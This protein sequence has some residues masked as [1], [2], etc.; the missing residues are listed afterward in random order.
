MT[1]AAAGALAARAGGGKTAAC[2]A[3]AC[4]AA[5]AAGVFAGKL[6]TVVQA[7]KPS[8][9]SARAITETTAGGGWCGA[10]HCGCGNRSIRWIRLSKSNAPVPSGSA[11]WRLLRAAVQAPVPAFR[12][13]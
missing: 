10:L 8:A 9:L 3:A 1:G 6:I 12:R 7:A 11:R 4:A 5:N 2:A 13:K